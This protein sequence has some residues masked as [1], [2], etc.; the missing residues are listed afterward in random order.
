MKILGVDVIG[1]FLVQVWE[2]SE[3][4][5]NE[6]EDSSNTLGIERHKKNHDMFNKG[7]HKREWISVWQVNDWTIRKVLISSVEDATNSNGDSF[8]KS[9]IEDHKGETLISSGRK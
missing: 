9:M 6:D 3:D 4:A 2:Y 8:D 7:C 1:P 5:T